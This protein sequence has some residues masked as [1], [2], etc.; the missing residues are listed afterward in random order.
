M[1]GEWMMNELLVFEITYEKWINDGWIDW[2]MM[3]E[4]FMNWCVC[5]HGYSL[6]IFLALMFWVPTL[7]KGMRLISDELPWSKHLHGHLTYVSSQVILVTTP[8]G[9]YCYAHF[10][11]EENKAQGK[12]RFF[13]AW[14]HLASLSVFP[15]SSNST[16]FSLL[17]ILHIPASFITHLVREPLHTPWPSGTSLFHT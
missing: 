17:T 7:E 9:R 11:N 14:V 12:K 16:I 13:Q 5:Y 1:D 2:W 4:Q 8:R 3:R 6:R 10:A 15:F